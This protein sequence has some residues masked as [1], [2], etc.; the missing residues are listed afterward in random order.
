MR[1]AEKHLDTEQLAQIREAEVRIFE[2]LATHFQKEM[3]NGYLRV[4]NPML[5][6]HAFTSLLMLANRE[7]V[8]N[9]NGGSIEELAEELVALFLDG[10]V[11]RN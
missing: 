6:A 11:K 3:D 8:R 5:L 10:A 7:D 1:E 4:G 9:M 2:V